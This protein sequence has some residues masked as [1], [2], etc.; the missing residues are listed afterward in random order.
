MENFGYVLLWPD[1]DYALGLAPPIG[2]ANR[3]QAALR[4]G[5]VSCWFPLP[6]RETTGP[7]NTLSLHGDWFARRVLSTAFLSLK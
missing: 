4:G 6:I 1:L 7:G 5:K 3:S 2:K